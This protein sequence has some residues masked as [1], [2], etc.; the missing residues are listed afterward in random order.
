VAQ[1]IQL[2]SQP[3]LAK[4]YSVV[5]FGVLAQLNAVSAVVAVVG[6]LQMHLAL[7][8]PKEDGESGELLGAGFL[9]STGFCLLSTCVFLAWDDKFFASQVSF[10]IPLLSTGLALTLCY[11]NLLRGWQTAHGQFKA[12]S[13][14]AIVRSVSIVGIQGLLG[15]LKIDNGLVYGALCGE[16]TAVLGLAVT[17]YSPSVCLVA[18]G[19]NLRKVWRSLK[20]YR[21]FSVMGTIQELVSVAVFMLPLYLFSRT[22][23]L[24][25]GG[26]YAM[27]NKLTWAPVTLIG[28]ASAQVIYQHFARL[29]MDKLK[30]SALLTLDIRFLA[31]SCAGVIAAFAAPA[32]MKA[33]LG[34]K[35]AL[36]SQMS[37]WIV[38]WGTAFLMAVPCR[39]CYRVL[40]WQRVQML[41]DVLILALLFGSFFQASR[42]DPVITM[43]CVAVI[44]VMQ[45][46]VLTL[47]MRL[48]LRSLA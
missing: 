23:S 43:A 30:V 24:E 22:Y 3:F 27:A 20:S 1:I 6:T 10:V 9:T 13:V 41:V 29:N 5:D 14:L 33:I 25:I 28:G 35:W 36:A 4:I 46:V 7:V 34:D 15:F 48:R 18:A 8:L 16:A 31:F 12:L 44:G 39:V 38:L 37:A 11:G 45:N 2:V 47:L 42:R 21:D 32:I 19:C 40:R 17:K 26:Q